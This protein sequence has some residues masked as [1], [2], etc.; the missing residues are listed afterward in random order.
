MGPDLMWGPEH[1][2]RSGGIWIGGAAS[3]GSFKGLVLE[4]DT[5]FCDRSGKRYNNL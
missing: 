3:F 5:S 1:V 2:C 4:A